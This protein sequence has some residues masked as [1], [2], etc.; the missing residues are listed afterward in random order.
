MIV[1][2][3]VFEDVSLEYEKPPTKELT[4]VDKEQKKTNE[5]PLKAIRGVNFKI[6][7]AEKVAVVGRTGAGKSSIMA[8]LF[9]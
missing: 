1:G 6:K 4:G 3:I 2:E 8:A 5:E 7:A 9:Q